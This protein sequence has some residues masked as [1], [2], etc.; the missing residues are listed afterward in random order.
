M[1]VYSLTGKNK[2]KQVSPKVSPEEYR[3]MMRG[4]KLEKIRLVSASLKYN[5][6]QPPMKIVVKSAEKF[7]KKKESNEVFVYQD[8]TLVAQLPKT[9]QK[10][11]NI[12]CCYEIVFKTDKD[13]TE[14]FFKIYADRSLPLNTWPYFREFVSSMVARMDLPPLTLPLFKT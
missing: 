10:G 3:N 2:E 11:V 12:K 5:F 4:L 14:E 13:F 1:E 8:Y 6:F 9:N 7:E